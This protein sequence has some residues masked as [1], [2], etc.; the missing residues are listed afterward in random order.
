MSQLQYIR[1]TYSV[2]AYRG[3]RVRYTGDGTPKD[4]VIRYARGAY[5][6][7]K[8]DGD[9]IV[10]TL[11]PTWEVEYLQD[12]PQSPPHSKECCA[13]RPDRFFAD[14]DC[15]FLDRAKDPRSDDGDELPE[16]M[17]NLKR[18]LARRRS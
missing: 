13:M 10:R 7:V 3:M 9:Q 5:L 18:N 14:C 1:R 2:P 12:P 15:G 17:E 8:F 4:G 16:A 6:G 11:H